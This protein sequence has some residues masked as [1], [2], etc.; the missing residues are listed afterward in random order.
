LAVSGKYDVPIPL[1]TDYGFILANDGDE[2]KPKPRYIVGF[3]KA[4]LVVSTNDM[5]EFKRA[6]RRIKRGTRVPWYDT[7]SARRSWGLSD[8]MYDQYYQALKSAGLK[9][10]ENRA[11]YVT[12][13]C[14]VF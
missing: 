8:A 4:G 13:Y 10:N 9:T 6:L 12:C 3:R 14:E 11:D 7:C 5:S 1:E 2:K